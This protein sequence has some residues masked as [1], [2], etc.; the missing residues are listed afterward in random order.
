MSIVSEYL[1]LT[2]NWKSERGENIVVLYQN[3]S[4]FEIFAL[5]DE[6]GRIYGSNIEDVS[7]ICD[8]KIA[9]KN[10]KSGNNTVLMAGFKIEAIEKYITKLSNS[11]YIIPIYEQE[12]NKSVTG[13]SVSGNSVSGFI[14]KLTNIISP[15]T[16]W[17]NE[18]D[19]ISN[20]TTC[21]WLHYYKHRSKKNPQERITIGLSNLDIFTGKSSIFEFSNEYQHDPA[22]YDELQRYISINNPSEIL[23]IHNLNDNI[24]NDIIKFT[25]IECCSVVKIDINN[26][27]NNLTKSAEKCEKQTYQSEII[28]KFIPSFNDEIFFENYMNYPYATQ[29]FCFLIDYVSRH[30]PNLVN[31]IKLPVFE[32]CSDRLVLANHSLLQLNIINDNRYNGKLS[33]VCNFLNNCITSM[34]KRKFINELLNPTK[35]IKILNDIYNITEHVLNKR[36]NFINSDNDNDNDNSNEKSWEV[37]R[38]HLYNIKDIEKLTRKLIIKKITPRDIS[39]LFNTINNII[40]LNKIVIKDE[41]LIEYLKNYKINEDCEEI[42]NYIN[43]QIDIEKAENINDMSFDSL[44]SYSIN[45]ITFIKN[46]LSSSLDETIKNYYDSK[47]K[48]ECIREFLSNNVALSEKKNDKNTQY[49]KIHETSKSEDLLIGTKRRVG[50]LKNEI[51]SLIKKNNCNKVTLNYISKF[52]NKKEEFIFDISSLD[53]SSNGSSESNMYITSQQIRQISGIIQESKE[54]II[55]EIISYYNIFIDT[56]INYENILSNICEYIISIDTLQ[57]R[58]YIAYTYNYCKP[59]I[60]D[61][62]IINEANDCGEKTKSY[63][64]I[65]GIRH[66]LIEHIQNREL[67][68]TNNI[69]IGKDINGYLIY[70]TNAVG[71]T[72][73]IRSI[74]ISL[75]MAQSGLY[76]PCNSFIYYPYSYL[77][78]RILGNDN[79]FKGQSTFSV[80]MSELRTILNMANKDSLILGD[81]LCSGTEQGSA[82][83]IFASGLEYLDSL[84]SSYIFATH[85]HEINKWPEITNIEKLKMMHMTVFY[86]KTT[87]KLIYDRKLKD[88]AGENMYGLEVCKSL[89]LP[90]KFL[91]RAHEIRMK[92][93]PETSNITSFKTSH[94]NKNKIMGICELCKNNIGEEVHHLQHQSKVNGNNNYINSFHKNHLG[95]LITVCNECH[96][97]FHETNIQYKKIKTSEGYDIIVE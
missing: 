35:N 27:D 30:N 25:N 66:C 23:I 51:N 58:C 55:K 24:V 85:F 87:K 86:D 62:E 76:V 15:G 80:E 37:Y 73:L 78:T 11:G 21:I 13:N 92:Y 95:N 61:K 34:G 20:S 41:I 59:I 71:K 26:K 56:L 81:E 10:I 93:Y 9:T 6:N 22:T 53:Y 77:F 43:S 45:N 4:F 96:D 64:E 72:S 29:S 54:I 42:I 97:K 67:Y 89:N 60:Q 79:L 8:L 1:K 28:K 31:K 12:E 14:R 49:I 46:G 57:N 17:L 88:G 69:T 90:Q 70:G 68:V 94:F 33:S 65:T 16:L 39:I 7:K 47:D 50:L 48:F 82:T 32:N 74:G 75:I 5:Q 38:K 83:S 18:Q 2:E 36:I 91:D 19:I 52:D 63:M 84:N 40:S 3:G 44:S